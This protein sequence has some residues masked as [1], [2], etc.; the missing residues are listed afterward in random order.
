MAHTYHTTFQVEYQQYYC[1]NSEK[2]ESGRFCHSFT[3]SRILSVMREIIPCEISEPYISRRGILDVALGHS[4]GVHGHELLLDLIGSGLPF[5]NHFRL[6]RSGLRPHSVSQR[7]LPPIVTILKIVATCYCTF[8]NTY[9][10][11]PNS[12][13]I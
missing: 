10:L 1:N 7:I 5:L 12:S 3:H 11:Q 2:Y 8:P 6:K 4:P 9:I 13:R